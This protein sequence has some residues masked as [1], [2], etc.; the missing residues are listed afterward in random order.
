MS[1]MFVGS[2]NT[3][4]VKRFNG[5]T[6]E[7]IDDFIKPSSGGL[8]YTQDL[9]FGPDGNLYVS[10]RGNQSILKYNPQ[11]GEFI[12]N[13]TK[14]YVLQDPTKF[15]F[16]PDG[17]LYVCQWGTVKKKIVRFDSQTGNFIDEF[18]KIDLEGPSGHAWDSNGNF[19]VANF[20]SKDVKKFDID[21]NFVSVFINSSFLQG[22]VNLW[23]G[24]DNN[25]FVLDWI[26][27]QVKEFDAISGSFKKVFISGL[28]NPEGFAFGTDNNIYICDWTDNKVVR[29]DGAGNL[30]DVFASGGNMQAPNSV[31]FKNTATTG[32]NDSE[33]MPLKLILNQ[34][35]PNP[36]N[37][38]TK[39]SFSINE[40]Q[41]VNLSIYNSLGEKVET[42][43]NGNLNPGEYEKIWNAG[44]MSSG[45]YF[46][47]LEAYNFYKVKKM[48][49]NK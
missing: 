24:K 37:P 31:I 43:I 6:G 40:T 17:K 22:P 23:F 29:F 4:S 8:S 39:I 26:L 1:E 13:F 33:P 16:A 12:E 45:I 14:G 32:F 18:T 3:H 11:T 9:A 27:G 36:F 34:N 38:G 48:I 7:Y 28:K 15:T 42:I 46:Y 20:N 35:Y 44:N 30:I 25:L 49:L 2:R 41:F 19:Y 5:E 47:K 10:G 21:G